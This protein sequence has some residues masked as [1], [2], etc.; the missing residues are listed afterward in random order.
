MN[1]ESLRHSAQV[2]P[3]R[4]G[5]ALDPA[6]VERL[7]TG[8][9]P[10]QQRKL[11]PG[12]APAGQRPKHP[13]PSLKLKLN[14]GGTGPVSPQFDG[15]RSP[16]AWQDSLNSHLSSFRSNPKPIGS[17]FSAKLQPISKKEN[18]EIRS[19]HR[20]YIENVQAVGK[21]FM[22]T[23]CKRAAIGVKH[24]IDT[25]EPSRRI[26]GDDPHEPRDSIAEKSSRTPTEKEDVSQNKSENY[27]MNHYQTNIFN[28][29]QDNQN[30]KSTGF[31]I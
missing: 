27:V 3:A 21:H 24:G 28:Q 26:P 20:Q 7:D 22:Q 6:C 1:F 14:L 30:E 19:L 12:L 5:A 18:P 2:S 8:P 31:E 10:G 4:D 25:L 23:Y 17:L 13:N 11:E 15:R 16:Q 9:P 29:S